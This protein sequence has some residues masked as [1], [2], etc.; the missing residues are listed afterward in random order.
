MER[1]ISSVRTSLGRITVRAML[2]A[3]VLCMAGAGSVAA[4]RA[5]VGTFTIDERFVDE[6][7][8]AACGFEVIVD[9]SGRGE[10]QILSDAQGNAT[11]ARVHEVIDGT[12]S[13]NG[14]VLQEIDRHTMFFDLV[15]GTSR[16]IGIVF[17]VRSLDGGIAIMDVG[18]LVASADGNLAF[19]AGPHPALDGNLSGLCEALGG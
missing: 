16:D 18:R 1:C 7:V 4:S 15:D 17:Q 10:Y 9:L 8:S 14:T 13:G 6:G 12:M 11:A 3:A 5:E 19:E 2:G